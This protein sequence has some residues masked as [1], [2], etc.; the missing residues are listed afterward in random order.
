LKLKNIKIFTVFE[1]KFLKL[2]IIKN[3]AF[4]EKKFQPVQT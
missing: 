4:F 1:K 3:L 2:K